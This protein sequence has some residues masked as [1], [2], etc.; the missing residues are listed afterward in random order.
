MPSITIDFEPDDQE[1]FDAEYD[2]LQEAIEQQCKVEFERNFGFGGAG[3][4]MVFES[5]SEAKRTDA[6]RV[7][8]ALFGKRAHPRRRR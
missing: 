5:N 2:R 4:T 1:Q 7:A 3:I 8:T 6:E